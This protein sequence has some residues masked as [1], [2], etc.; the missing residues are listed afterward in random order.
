M[1]AL[2]ALAFATPPPHKGLSLP[3]TATR[4]L[5]M[6]KARGQ[7]LHPPK[8]GHRSPTACKYTVSDS[9][10]LPSPGFFSSFAHATIRYRSL[11]VFSL[12]RWSSQIPTGFPVPRSTRV[13]PRPIQPFAYRSFTFCARV[14]QPVRL[15]FIDTM[16]VVPRPHRHKASGLGCS[17]FARR[18]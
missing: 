7:S 12:T 15:D 11:G 2:F 9:I 1:V 13:P 18:Y 5:I 8:R 14:F 3:Q 6:Q 4:R 16:L 17:R 10:S